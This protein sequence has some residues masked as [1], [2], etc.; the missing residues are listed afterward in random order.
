MVGAER[1]GN[2][3]AIAFMGIPMRARKRVREDRGKVLAKSFALSLV[4]RDASERVGKRRGGGS[5]RNR[6]KKLEGR[7]RISSRRK[8]GG[9]LLPG[10]SASL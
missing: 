6:P 4:R 2:R 7:A 9:C 10:E 3:K 5:S 1:R 8:R